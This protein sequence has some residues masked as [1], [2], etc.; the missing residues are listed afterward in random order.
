MVLATFTGFL[1]YGLLK[2]SVGIRLTSEEEFQGADLSI[3]QI[4]A[5]PEDEL[6]AHDVSPTLDDPRQLA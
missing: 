4:G 6:P 5:Y 3:H 1:V 2:A